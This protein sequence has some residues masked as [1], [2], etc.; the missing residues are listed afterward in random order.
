MNSH[1]HNGLLDAL[2]EAMVFRG[3]WYIRGSLRAHH[4]FLQPLDCKLCA[5][6]RHSFMLLCLY[7]LKQG[8]FTSTLPF[9]QHL[10]PSPPSKNRINEQNGVFVF[11]YKIS[12]AFIKNVSKSFRKRRKKNFCL[13]LP[14]MLL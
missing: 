1:K 7:E 6:A 10:C 2:R 5:V 9:M 11:T 3:I 14:C 13:S 4:S 8:L 12:H